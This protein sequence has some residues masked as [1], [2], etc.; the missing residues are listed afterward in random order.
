MYI[1]LDISYG[2]D[3][4]FFS[5]FVLWNGQGRHQQQDDDEDDD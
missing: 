3:L 5:F 2:R 1:S 4:L